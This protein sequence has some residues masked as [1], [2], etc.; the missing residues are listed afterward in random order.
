M[1][2][3]RALLDDVPPLM[4]TI[5]DVDSSCS[6]STT[7]VGL[8]EYFEDNMEEGKA[9]LN[10]REIALILFTARGNVFSA[11]TAHSSNTEVDAP[12]VDDDPDMP[13]LC[14]NQYGSRTT[15]I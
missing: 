14:P 7:G 6:N 15:N 2:E 9:N 12:A 11:E 10:T 5:P 8:D 3:G 13:A 1:D 4:D